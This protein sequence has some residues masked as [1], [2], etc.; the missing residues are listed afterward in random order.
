MSQAGRA[1]SGCVRR[2]SFSGRIWTVVES[3]DKDKARC[4]LIGG[5]MTQ[6]VVK[7]AGTVHRPITA[8]SAFVAELLA[9]LEERS[10]DGAPRHLG[11]ADGMDVFTYLPGWVPARF[12]QWTDRQ[13]VAAGRLLRGLHDATRGS[14]LAGTSPVVC[15][16][17]VGP[18][19]VVFRGDTPLAFIDFDTAA[20]GSPL[21][22]VGYMA[23]TWCVTSRD[24]APAP[25]RQAHQVRVLVDAY[26]LSDPG[27][28]VVIDAMLERQARNARFWAEAAARLVPAV[29]TDQQVADRIA[30]SQREHAYVARH[31]DT[32]DAALRQP[33]SGS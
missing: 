22:D 6:G 33:V 32:F 10:F 21:E 16:H 26:G 8:A 31:R 27:R 1:A 15:H 2:E 14:A 3:A 11:Q 18:N 20:P 7:V 23:W 17:D 9:L 4:F 12:Q 25:T 28:G 13:V 19:N 5:R 30:W 24:D 29:V